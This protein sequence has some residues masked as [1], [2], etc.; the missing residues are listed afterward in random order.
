AGIQGGNKTYQIEGRPVQLGGDVIIKIDDRTV[1]KVDDIL[2]Y[3]EN[4][5]KIGDNVTVTV[6]KGGNENATK[7]L[8]VKLIERPE[9]RI[10]SL[11]PSLGIIGLDVNSQIAQSM[12]LTRTDGFLITGVIDKSPA[13]NASLRGGYILSEINGR[14]VQLGGDVII[15]IDNRTVKNQQDIKDYLSNKKIGESI[16][17]TIL[18]NGETLTKTV[19]LGDFKQKPLSL[20]DRGMEPFSPSLPAPPPSQSPERTPIPEGLLKDFMDHCY[21]AL[22]REICDLFINPK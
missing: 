9:I 7:V 11:T 4:Y 5:K 1:K 2:S 22:D 17:L 21:K 15:K 10:R 6:L 16:T 3:L 13:Y 20:E 19:S 12:N 14:P 18:R 8:N